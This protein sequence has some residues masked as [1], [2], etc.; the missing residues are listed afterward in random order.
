MHKFLRAVGF[1]QYT[2]KKQVQKLIRDIIIHADERSYT[3]V[4]KKTLV[5]EFDRNFAEDIGIAVCGEFDRTIRT[6]SI[7][8]FRTCAPILSVQQR[9]SQS[10]A[11][12]RRSPMREFATIRRLVFP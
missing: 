1:S 11:T 7:I 10:S 12:Q 5:A 6:V 8:I 2:E 3:T 4:G 9:I